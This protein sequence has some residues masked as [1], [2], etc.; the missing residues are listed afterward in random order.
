MGNGNAPYETRD[1]VGCKTCMIA[2]SYHHRG[3]FGLQFSSIEIKD[4]EQN[5]NFT[6]AFHYKDEQGRLG[7]DRCKGEE[8]G[9]LCVKY[10]NHVARD[11]L[12]T[13]LKSSWRSRG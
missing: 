12:R 5:A 9:P 8:E 10:C 3:A 13:L 1:C 2:C 11:E 6:I 4:S 7:C